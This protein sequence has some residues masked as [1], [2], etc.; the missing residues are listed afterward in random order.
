MRI[1]V[2]YSNTILSEIQIFSILFQNYFSRIDLCELREKTGSIDK[3][4]KNGGTCSYNKITGRVSCECP[5]GFT[6]DRCELLENYCRGEPCKNGLCKN[7][8]GTYACECSPGWTGANCT[9]QI[10]V[11]SLTEDCLAQNTISVQ[12]SK[13]S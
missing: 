9:E 4:C 6:G 3:E 13:H 12:H 11:C 10:S 7:N 5:S 2:T 1:S 8:R